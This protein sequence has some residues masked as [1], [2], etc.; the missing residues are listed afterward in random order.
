MNYFL[1]LSSLAILFAFLM[2]SCSDDEDDGPETDPSPTASYYFQATIDGQTVTWEQGKDGFFA[3]LGSGG[4]TF[5]ETQSSTMT[6]VD[7]SGGE[8]QAA[9]FVTIEFQETFPAT[10]DIDD[11]AGM[12]QLGS[13]NYSLSEDYDLNDGVSIVY[14]PDGDKIWTSYYGSQATSS[15]FEITELI[16]NANTA[17]SPKIFSA[18]FKCTLYDEEGNSIELSAGD[19]RG[20]AL[21]YY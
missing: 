21:S 1:K 19:Y 6:K 12:Y 5:L 2:V 9:P 13:Y 20:L 17:E 18:E 10:A 16:D 7:L 3:G 4:G 14:S 8:L 15:T 11:I